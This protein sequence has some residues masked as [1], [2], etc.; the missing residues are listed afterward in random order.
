MTPAPPFPSD[1]A[2]ERRRQAMLAMLIVA[3]LVIPLSAWLGPRLQANAVGKGVRVGSDLHAATFLDQRL[4]VSGHEGAGYLTSSGQ[5]HQ[6]PSLDNMDAMAWAASQAGILVGGHAGLFR[7]TNGGSSFS[8]VRLNLPVTDI[9]ALG[10]EGTTVYAASPQAGVLVSHDGG[11]TFA[12]VSKSGTSFIGAIEVDPRNTERAVAADMR[13]GVVVTTDGGVSWQ[14]RGG[15]AGAMNVARNPTEP[16]QIVAIGMG[17]AA[18]SDTN[19]RAWRR[20][21]IPVDTTAAAFDSD[22]H[23]FAVALDGRRA[24]VYAQEGDAWKPL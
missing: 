24:K 16:A 5:W 22:G 7:S 6:I 8:R 21:E 2:G 13:S 12:V 9:H 3:A 18:I 17:A 15:V 10:G 23:L 1:R 11:Q 4:F 14:R 20:L 19:G